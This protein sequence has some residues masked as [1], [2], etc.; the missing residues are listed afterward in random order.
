MALNSDQISKNFT[1]TEALW[2]PQ[3][4]RM[5]RDTDGLDDIVKYNLKR[6]YLNIMQ[7][8]RDLIGQPIVV[9]CSYRPRAYNAAIGGAPNS[10]HIE[11]KAVDWSV[12]GRDC[13]EI[14]QLIIPECSRLGF[15]VEAGTPTWIHIDIRR[16]YGLFKP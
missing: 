15:R 1:W 10:A 5:A 7:P 14:R 12:P 16:P 2:L 4:G 8:L 6:V 13:E 11:G 3:W 9:H